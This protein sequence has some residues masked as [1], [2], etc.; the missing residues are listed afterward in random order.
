MAASNNELLA[1]ELTS[2]CQT[3]TKTSVFVGYFRVIYCELC[4]H[5]KRDSVFKTRSIWNEW[6]VNRVFGVTAVHV[7]RRKLRKSVRQQSRT[8]V[9]SNFTFIVNGPRASRRQEDSLFHRMREANGNYDARE[10]RFEW[11]TTVT[12]GVLVEHGLSPSV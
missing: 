6:R 2:C 8:I 4:A 3:L 10:T 5:D 11:K 9:Y 12:G 1:N 7:W